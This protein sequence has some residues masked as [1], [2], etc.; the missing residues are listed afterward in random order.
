MGTN[1]IVDFARRHGQL[2]TVLCAE[3]VAGTLLWTQRSSIKPVG[4]FDDGTVP[5]RSSTPRKLRRCLRTAL[6]L[7]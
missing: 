1:P 2:H 4:V 5:I 6:P 7:L 3:T